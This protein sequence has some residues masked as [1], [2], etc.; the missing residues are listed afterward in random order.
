MGKYKQIT[1]R[2]RHEFLLTLFQQDQDH[3]E[4]KELNGYWLVKQFNGNTKVWEVAIH[5]PETYQK[6]LDFG[7]EERRRTATDSPHLS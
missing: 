1:N 7:I 3:F 4:A 5:T 2:R 6:F